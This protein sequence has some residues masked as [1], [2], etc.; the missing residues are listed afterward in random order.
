[1]STYSDTWRNY[2]GITAKG[3]VHRL[4]EHNKEEFSDRRGG[5]IKKK[6]MICPQK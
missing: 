2:T 4:V 1:M 6:N 3:Y 5:H